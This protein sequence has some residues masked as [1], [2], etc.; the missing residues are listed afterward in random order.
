MAISWQQY[1]ATT[2]AKAT[3]ECSSM[4]RQQ[5]A[6]ATAC[7]GNSMHAA[8]TACMQRQQHA[9]ATAEQ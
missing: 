4:Q 2:H 7:S 8:T 5:H 6:A 3:T 1:M 9:A